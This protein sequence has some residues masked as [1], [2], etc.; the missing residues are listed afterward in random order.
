MHEHSE[1]IVSWALCVRF[2]WGA[3]QVET[4]SQSQSPLALLDG[5]MS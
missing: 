3:Q 2:S 5:G 4:G 1:N